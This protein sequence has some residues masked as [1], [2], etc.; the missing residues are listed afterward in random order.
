[1]ELVTPCHGARFNDESTG[2]LLM[3]ALLPTIVAGVAFL[4]LGVITRR[5]FSF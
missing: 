1:M 2:G 3:G 4:L 5:L